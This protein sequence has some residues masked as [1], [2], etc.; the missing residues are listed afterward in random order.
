MMMKRFLLFATL[1]CM[2]ATVNTATAQTKEELQELMNSSSTTNTKKE[3][4]AKEEKPKAKKKE[5]PKA[6]KQEAAK[7]EEQKTEPAK[8][9]EPKAEKKK[10]EPKAVSVASN[11][12]AVLDDKGKE[13]PAPEN[14]SWRKNK[15]LGK[16]LTQRGSIANG[17]RYYETA[18]AK[19]PKKTFLNQNIADGHMA[20]RD[21]AN[22]N[23]YY[24]TL[25]DLDSVKHK[26]PAALY[27]YALTEKYLGNYENAK[28]LFSKFSRITKDDDKQSDLR[29]NA[30]REMLGC[31][32]ALVYANNTDLPEFKTQLLDKNINQPL[33][34]FSP[35][36]KD[37]GTLYYGAWTS[38]DVVLENKKEKY[39]SY[40][41]LYISRNNNGWGKGE[42]V[43]GGINEQP[44]HVGNAAFSVDGN[45]LYYTGCLQDEMQRMRCSIYKSSKTSDGWSSGTKLDGS[46][47][48]EGTTSTH[49]AVGKNEAGEDV[50]YFSS[51]RN[52]GK[53]MDILYAKINED[54][55]VGKAKSVGPTINT[56]GDEITPSYD[57]KTN[58]LYFASNGHV[59][60][61]GTDIFKTNVNGGE[62]TEPKNMGTPINSSVDDMYFTWSE[63]QATGFLVSN[64]TGG[65]GLKSQTCCD[66]IYAVEKSRLYLAVTGLLQNSKAGNKPVTSGLVTLYDKTNGKE[67]KTFYA[68]DGSYFFDLEPERE[69]NL[70]ARKKDF[71]DLM[72]SVSTI[73]KRV[74]DT[75]TLD[76]PLVEIPQPT[77]LVGQKIGVV[78]WEYDKDYLT[79]G[80]PDTLKR[81]VEFMNTNPQYVLEVGSHTD[82]KGSDEY[83][84]KLSQRRSDAV[85][86]FLASKKIDKSRLE[87]KAYG[88]SVPVEL[89]EDPAGTDNPTG[90]TKNRRT[91]FK[92]VKEFTPAEL[93]AAKKALEEK[94]AA[95][96]PAAKA[97]A[98][99]AAEKK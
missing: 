45:T 56:R 46:I 59:N 73:G 94:K 58:T 99:P 13:L 43:K 18:L 11:S 41:R 68:S 9:E 38:D 91:E 69:Y 84:I 47:N 37:A 2:A 17:V 51:D 80:A 29:K 22:A 81:V 64:R 97:E 16:K 87:S 60:I 3:T 89:N 85:V 26:N 67:V 50:L 34:D 79:D 7:P 98:K 33:T 12:K 27:Q 39:A 4:K 54:G 52:P 75:V 66:D 74:N 48:L 6:A 21:Y 23:R 15:K 28:A 19:K 32:L 62:W 44:Q 14:I 82:G 8:Q 20:L 92:V 88:E 57:F 61:G 65:F 40:S 24:H 86:K 55:S 30:N 5:E 76:F 31:D 35:L 90:R 83:N 71:E 95:K 42:E 10:E 49:P 96:K 72:L 36:L 1:L 77:T 70:I 53:G 63:T 78:Y 25:A 93:E